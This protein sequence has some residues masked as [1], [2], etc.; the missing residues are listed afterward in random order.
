[1]KNLAN[2]LT[3]ILSSFIWANFAFAED[4]SAPT[5]I[6]R[7]QWGADESIRSWEADY[8]K[9]SD[10]TIDY[11]AKKIVI[12]HTAS[13]QLPQDSDGTGQYK[14]KVRD[15]YRFHVF[16]ANWEEYPGMSQR[17]FGDLGYNYLVDPNG[18]IYQ[19]RYGGNGGIGAHVYGFN[20][21]TIGIALLGTY[22][23]KINGNFVSQEITPKAM[24]SLEK[25]VGWLAATNNINLSQKTEICGLN[26]K[27]ENI[28]KS[29]F[30]LVGHRDLGQT[31]CPGDDLQKALSEIRTKAEDF[32]G[33]YKGYVYQENSSGPIY[34]ISEGTK[35]SFK[36]LNAFLSQ[37]GQY[38]KVSVLTKS[39]L[40]IFSHKATV[41]YPDWSL[42][43]EFKSSDVFLILDGKKR[44]IEMNE[45]E[46]R[47]L[48]FDPSKIKAVS[49]DELNSYEDG[50]KI[51]YGKDGSLFTAD[52]VKI[53]Y[54]E[55]G[56]KRFITSHLLFEALGFKIPNIQKVSESELS[57]LLDGDI[58]KYPDGTL[59]KAK[60]SENIYLMDFGKKRKFWTLRQFLSL[61]YKNEKVI[62]IEASELSGL[63]DGPAIKWPSGT[64]VMA[65]GSPD[66][67][68]IIG[69]ERNRI[70][71]SEEFLRKGFKW[72]DI[73]PV[74]KEELMA[75]PLPSVEIQSGNLVKAEEK[76]EVYIVEG[77]NLYWIKTAQ[78]FEKR[79]YKWSDIKTV[80][81]QKLAKYTISNQENDIG[82]QSFQTP[83][84][85][86]PTP[87]P[88]PVQEQKIGEEPQIRVAIFSPASGY[89]I[90]IKA[91]NAYDVYLDGKILVSKIAEAQTTYLLDNDIDM[92][93]IPKVQNTIF[94]IL[95]YEDRPSW[96]PEVN[97]NKFR[98]KIEIKYSQKSKKIWVVNELALEDYLFGLAESVQGDPLEFLKAMITSS[99]S[100]AVFHIQNGGKYGKD[101]IFHLKNTSSDQVYKGYGR[102]EFA[103][104][105]IKAVNETSGYVVYFKGVPIRGLYSSG[106]PIK[107][108]D[109][110]N[111]FGG[112]FCESRYDYLRGGS[113][114]PVGAVY[115]NTSCDSINHCVGLMADG[116]RFLAQSGKSWQ[117]II[118]YYYLGVEIKKAY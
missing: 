102:E 32:F 11:Q 21:G 60:G 24:V 2:I 23:A 107:T 110:C 8:P 73:I 17:G 61:G 22:G 64:L 84:I 1:M 31:L 95:S 54:I 53:Y 9:F 30:G 70:K 99:R 96:K 85:P 93:F 81:S 5:I 43:R 82:F 79:G 48:G 77:D 88:T 51:K 98:G 34:K 42:I 100:Y 111:V 105:I 15:I 26:T 108:R 103:S 50:Q 10:G 114:S 112:E 76:P 87:T 56:K 28:C 104:D 106:A 41:L 7:A 52:G 67:Y 3:V 113:E 57:Y 83:Q 78:D 19:G 86:Q 6:T 59:I 74:S 90:K 45:E 109:A 18:N 12:H 13:L 89:R 44:K 101:E 80:S 68:I 72:S 118:K 69:G 49:I 75:Y 46:F 92:K 40:D 66:V 55:N 39:Q 63:S 36:D 16:N 117:D 65:E 20:K 58:M 29:V 115:K 71:S 35:E 27:G 94:E 91:N 47:K 97:Y 37:G 62:E 33:V 25:L 38:Q 14:S 4:F 116:A